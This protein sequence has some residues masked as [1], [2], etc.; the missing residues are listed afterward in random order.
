MIW[1]QKEQDPTVLPL[2]ECILLDRVPAFWDEHLK[3]ST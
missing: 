2:L 1:L 3:G